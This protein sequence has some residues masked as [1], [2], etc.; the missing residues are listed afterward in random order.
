MRSNLAETP[1]AWFTP[2]REWQ[3]SHD[4]FNLLLLFPFLS[5]AYCCQVVL[6]PPC[7]L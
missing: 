4:A 3:K 6:I 2:S 1:A 5:C 7:T